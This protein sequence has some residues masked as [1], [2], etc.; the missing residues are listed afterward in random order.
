MAD[1]RLRLKALSEEDLAVIS[2]MVQD[3]VLKVADM[4]F[5]ARRHCFAMVM[6]RFR[7][8]KVAPALGRGM[9]DRNLPGLERVRSGLHFEG[10]LAARCRGV[11]R[12]D[13]EAVLELLAIAWEPDADGVGGAVLL[14]FAGGATVRLEAEC[15]EAYLRDLTAPWPARRIPVHEID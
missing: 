6:N 5:D 12:D 10:V 8:E 9:Q 4:G 14:E 1:E 7:W 2:A 15:L 13:E 3:A 11:P